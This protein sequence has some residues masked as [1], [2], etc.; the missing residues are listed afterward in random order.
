MLLTHL[1]A[2]SYKVVPWKNGTG[3]TTELVI[4][5]A[6]ASMQTG[7]DW[8]I[9]LAQVPRSGPFSTFAGYDRTIMLLTGDPMQLV[10]ESHG[11]HRLES[12]QAYAFSGAWATTGILTGEPVED[13]NVM[14]QE[15]FGRASLTV[16]RGDDKT[17]WKQAPAAIR[18]IWAFRGAARLEF[19]DQKIDLTE[20]NSLLIEDGLEGNL[21]LE[22]PAS[23]IL[24]VGIEK[25]AKAGRLSQ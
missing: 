5:P 6:Q 16:C 13:F 12:M 21:R 17:L 22:S 23:I 15:G 11:E 7:F 9:S 14:V 24:V 1:S 2:P 3:S 25:F 10:H 18:F 8:R 4:R 19:P 20:Q